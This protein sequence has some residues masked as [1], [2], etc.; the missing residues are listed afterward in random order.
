MARSRSSSSSSS[1]SWR[2]CNPTYYLKRPKRLA[3]LLIVF[4][5]ATLVVWDRQTL[6]REHEV[7]VSKLREEISRLHN[8]VGGP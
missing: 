3:L 8:M 5:S 4:V 2:Y 7:E 1:S 6:V